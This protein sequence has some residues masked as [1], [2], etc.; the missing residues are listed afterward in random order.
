M[1]LASQP[2]STIDDVVIGSQD[3]VGAAQHFTYIEMTYKAGQKVPLPQA[4][5]VN[6]QHPAYVRL[7]NLEFPEVSHMFIAHD[8]PLRLER[9][10]AVRVVYVVPGK[11]EVPRER[12]KVEIMPSE[13]Y[14]SPAGGKELETVLTGDRTDPVMHALRGERYM[15]ETLSPKLV[16]VDGARYD[17]IDEVPM[18]LTGTARI[19]PATVVPEHVK[20]LSLVMLPGANVRYQ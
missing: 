3:P 2:H 17:N 12:G 6:F 16:R 8:T 19:T 9:G 5:S 18:T 14:I 10:G 20:H 13:I 7:N 15:I 1:V 4:V 11:V